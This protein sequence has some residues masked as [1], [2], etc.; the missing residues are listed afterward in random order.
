VT[1]GTLTATGTGAGA[2]NV[3]VTVANSAAITAE[4]RAV[5]FAVKAGTSSEISVAIGISIARNLIGWSEFGGSTPLTVTASTTNA[6]ISAAGAVLVRAADTTQI[7]ATVLAAAVAVAASLSSSTTGAVGGLWTDNKVAST[8]QASIAGAPSISTGAGGLTVTAS[9]TA[10]ITADAKAAA[11][12]ASLAGASATAI[13][14]GLALAH[15]TI[16]NDVRASIGSVGTIT[17]SGTPVVVT[18]TDDMTIKVVAIAVAVSTAMAGGGTGVAVAGGG[19]E[20]TNVVLGSTV[21]VIDGG[22]LGTAANQVHSVT[23]TATSTARITAEILSAAVSLAFGTSTGVG[24]AIG[25]SV[26]R[27]F[28]GW[29]PGSG[30]PSADYVSSATLTTGLAKGKTVRIDSGAREDDVYEY[31]GASLAGT[32]KLATQDY[33][34]R[35]LWKQVQ[36]TRAGDEI[37]AGVINASIDAAGALTVTAR[38]QQAIVAEIVAVA[39]GIAGGGTTGVAVSAAGVYVENRIAGD[40]RAVIEGDG[41][42]GIKASSVS[43][44]AEDASGIRT[45]A[46]AASVAAALS[47]STS[48]ASRSV[49]PSPSTT[50]R[51]APRPRSCPPIRGSGRPPATS[52]SRRARSGARCSPSPA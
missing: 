4:V 6:T 50:S 30:T 47:G 37:R 31:I 23:V 52:P 9:E 14:I 5:A 21:A 32:V 12:A 38:N 26:A 35:S 16:D 11:V 3:S 20:S 22:T 17:T 33:S 7:D 1:G 19:A 15:N 44:L 40:A 43:L 48:S 2:G 13:A 25:I 28:I 49:W 8:V 29:D 51:T 39:V 18:A 45:F 41:A 27:N 46:G 36:L 34:D 10:R 42:T 24:V